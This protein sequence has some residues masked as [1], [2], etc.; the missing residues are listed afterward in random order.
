MQRLALLILISM[1]AVNTLF[2]IYRYDVS[3]YKDRA[4]V[5][6]AIQTKDYKKL[7]LRRADIWGCCY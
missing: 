1:I 7:E 3:L 2:M 6:E 4:K 5:M